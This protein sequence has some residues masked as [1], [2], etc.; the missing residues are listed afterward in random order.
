MEENYRVYW[1]RYK[2]DVPEGEHGR[3]RVKKMVVSEADF[4]FQKIRASINSRKIRI[5]PVGEYTSLYV[6]GA[7]WM[8]D[9]P[10]E[11]KDHYELFNRVAM[12]YTEQCEVL[13]HGLG[14][15]MALNGC[16]L[17]GAHHITVVEKNQDVIA[18]VG[19]HWQEKWPDCIDIIHDDAMK[20]KPPKGKR[21]HII[22][23]DIWEGIC[24]DNLND[25]GALHR[26]FAR[27]TDWQESWGK[28]E[29]QEARKR[30]S[31]WR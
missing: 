31:G 24:S 19:K 12:A 6:G 15:G 4:A 1:E 28:K 2:V 18:L 8:T 5:V 16:L 27:R 7:L 3:A 13:L 21:W 23:H 26:R 20:W 25:M 22:W 9:T 14:L 11:I 30:S 17:N 29:C 10:D